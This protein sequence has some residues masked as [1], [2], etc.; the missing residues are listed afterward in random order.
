[1]RTKWEQSGNKV[2]IKNLKVG[3]EWEQ[4]GNKV[5][6]KW[7]KEPQSGPRMGTKCGADSEQSGNK[8]GTRTSKSDKN[9]N[10][11]G[12]TWGYTKWSAKSNIVFEA[13]SSIGK[14]SICYCIPKQ[15]AKTEMFS[16]TPPLLL[17]KS[18]E[19]QVRKQLGESDKLSYT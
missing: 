19:E 5:G 11:V 10:K 12:T 16:T 17:R 15:V 7:Q 1:M 9:G 8:V 4:S 6:T 14:I 3:Q 18:C 13:R 2:G